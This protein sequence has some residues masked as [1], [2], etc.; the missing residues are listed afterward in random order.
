[1]KH[2]FLAARIGVQWLTAPAFGC[3]PRGAPADT[4]WGQGWFMNNKKGKGTK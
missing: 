3:I 1:M 2:M 4:P